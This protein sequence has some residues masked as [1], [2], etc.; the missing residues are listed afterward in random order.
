M[1]AGANQYP[2]MAGVPALRHAVTAKIERVHGVRYDPDSEITITAGATQAIF[3][4]LLAI[5]RAGDEVVLIGRQGAQEVTV[6]DVAAALG[7]INY[8]V[9]SEILARVPRVV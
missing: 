6:D 5:V 9:V 1:A 7:T 8:E 4:A 2:P 3:T